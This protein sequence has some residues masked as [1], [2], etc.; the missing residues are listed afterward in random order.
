MLLEELNSSHT[1]D[2]SL[3][4]LALSELP[5]YADENGK[6]AKIK[7]VSGHFNEAIDEAFRLFKL[8]QTRDFETAYLGL[9][10]LPGS[11]SMIG[12]SSCLRALEPMG[13]ADHPKMNMLYLAIKDKDKDDFN[14]ARKDSIG[15]AM[16]VRSVFMALVKLA[17][18][19]LD[20]YRPGLAHGANDYTTA[21]CKA[22]LI[23]LGIPLKHPRI[24]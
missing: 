19:A 15:F 1:G 16:D 14:L 6:P 7:L 22:T 10:A 9:Q 3:I 8:S 23:K 13:F 11:R 18:N 4:N 12:I 5:A 2:I 21:I 24:F 20:P 17:L